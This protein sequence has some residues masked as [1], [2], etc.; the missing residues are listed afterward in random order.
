MT[1]I[2]NLWIKALSAILICG[3]AFSPSLAQNSEQSPKSNTY[4]SDSLLL[5]SLWNTYWEL[6]NQEKNDSSLKVCR[7]LISLGKNIGESSLD[8]SLY[9]KYAKAYGDVG[10]NLMILGDYDEALKYSLMSYE[11]LRQRFGPN[12]IR[13]SEVLVGIAF[14]YLARGD[15]ENTI[16]NI[17]KSIDVVNHLFPEGHYYL[18]NSEYNLS[19]VY[20][21][22]GDYEKAIIHLNRGISF[23]EKRN[24]RSLAKAFFQVNAAKCYL[25]IQ[26]YEKALQ[27]ARDAL[28]FQKLNFQHP[29][30]VIGSAFLEIG[31][32]EAAEKN[33]QKALYIPGIEPDPYRFDY[34]GQTLAKLGELHQR[35][36]NYDSSLKWYKESIQY[37]NNYK[38]K[39]SR[40]VFHPYWKIVGLYLQQNQLEKA[41]ETIDEVIS[42]LIPDYEPNNIFDTSQV[43]AYIP[44]LHLLEASWRKGNVLYALSLKENAIPFL[45]AAQHAY[46]WMGEILEKMQRGAHW[47]NSRL[48]LSRWQNRQAEGEI[49]TYLALNEIT[50]EESYLYKAFES[51]EKNK[52]GLLVSGLTETAFRSF[53][54]IPDSLIQKERKLR[55]KIS[56]FEKLIHEEETSGAPNQAKVASWNKEL[57]DVNND[58]N[59]LKAGLEADY[60]DYY[61]AV[62]A[63]KKVSSQQ[64]L[65]QLKPEECLIE[66][67]SGDSSLYIFSLT[68]NSIT[69]NSLPFSDEFRESYQ[70]LRRQLYE[71]TSGLLNDDQKKEG[72]ASFSRAAYHLYEQLLKPVLEQTSPRRLIIIPDGY[73]GYL[74]FHLLL[75]QPASDEQIQSQDYRGL[76]YLFGQYSIQLEYSSALLFR[77]DLRNLYGNAEIPYAGFAPT[78][79]GNELLANR[80]LD[81]LSLQ[82]LFPEVARNG[83]SGLAFNQP[84]VENAAA[85]FPEARVFQA[86]SATESNFKQYGFEANILH[87]AMH[88]L[89]NNENPLFSQLVFTQNAMEEEEDGFLHAYELYNTRLKA[90]LAVLSACNTGSGLL[91]DGEGI[92]S[93]ARAFKYAGCPNIAMSLW[94]ADDEATSQIMEEFFAQLKEEKGK[95]ESLRQAQLNYLQNLAPAHKTHPYYWAPFVMIGD[96]EPISFGKTGWGWWGWALGGVTLLLL[97]V[98]RRNLGSPNLFGDAHRA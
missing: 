29:Y 34:Y 55:E 52:A 54:G 58:F 9:E 7:Q 50:R 25:Q 60:S 33:L 5:I 82:R 42:L 1:L 36:G 59:E 35:R 63:P 28:S 70:T 27:L 93:L 37:W 30:F 79:Q 73:L 45:L 19:L 65:Q 62:H 66:Y 98:F 39:G 84:E 56:R 10:Y 32:Y 51:C 18:A 94:K 3:I 40:S 87:L 38:G 80:N 26:E 22:M 15:Y 23:H 8:S 53:A 68:N 71:H 2:K 77:E 91:A 88:G 21:Q 48:E 41:N 85:F 16:K 12:H 74:P 49:K 75:Q 81:S 96:D 78:Y 86:E 57:I 89:T 4:Q 69:V 43:T 44:S 17:Y 72:Y 11:K 97:F 13:I 47:E 61:Q 95:A 90:E 31:D 46:Q 83:L 24:P 6:L 14:N 67:F 92:L 64:I 76:S 20:K